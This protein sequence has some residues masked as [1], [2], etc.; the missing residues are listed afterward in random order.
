MWLCNYCEFWNET[1]C[2]KELWAG[3]WKKEIEFFNP[4][5]NFCTKWNS[6]NVQKK[7][8]ALL[9]YFVWKKKKFNYKQPWCRSLEKTHLRSFNCSA[10]LHLCRGISSHKLFWKCSKT[11]IPKDKGHCQ[12]KFSVKRSGSF[13][14]RPGNNRE[15]F[16]L[17]HWPNQLYICT[18]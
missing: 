8:Q 18:F 9:V 13:W 11:L 10:Q 4:C 3:K 17:P 7:L 12:F 6:K 14:T 5:C 2:E 15:S 1:P 16:S